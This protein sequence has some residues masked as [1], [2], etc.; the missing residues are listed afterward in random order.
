VD[1]ARL[2]GV[3]ALAGC[4]SAAA[5]A[6]PP[7]A[8]AIAAKDE[9]RH[10][11]DVPAV[12]KELPTVAEA[13]SGAALAIAADAEVHAHAWGETARG[14]FLAIVA[15]D[16]V[17]RDTMAGVVKTMQ[18]AIDD[19]LEV[20]EWTSSPDAED[21]AELQAR[22]TG[23]GT[24]GQLRASLVLDARRIPHALAAACFY[25]DR[26]PSVCENACTPLLAQLQL[27]E[28]PPATP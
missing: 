9:P 5:D 6:P 22:F 13:A 21:H 4:T 20:Q 16:G 14:C 26:Q 12:W 28:P 11:I 24:R 1:V 2:I 7:A 15:L 3:L 10:G 25:N 23:H 18:A 27:L 17:R 19:G 8:E